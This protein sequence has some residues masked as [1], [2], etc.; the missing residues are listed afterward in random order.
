MNKKGL[1]LFAPMIAIFTLVLLSTSIYYLLLQPKMGHERII[2]EKAFAIFDLEQDS[3]ISKFMREEGLEYASYNA[4]VNFGENSGECKDWSLCRPDLNK[5]REYLKEEYLKILKNLGVRIIERENYTIDL[6]IENNSFVV[7]ASTKERIF[8]S[9]EGVFYKIEHKSFNKR[10]N[11]D[12]TIYTTLYERYHIPLEKCQFKEQLI[13]D[14]K[15]KIK[16]DDSG[17][18]MYIKYEVTPEEDLLF[19]NPIIKFKVGKLGS[20]ER[21]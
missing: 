1:E 8:F 13:E 16:C 4:L 17:K 15:V 21:K 12:L 2:G 19:V 14:L 9:K 10:I 7:S 6:K 11:Y 20:L 3:E 5:F 18:E